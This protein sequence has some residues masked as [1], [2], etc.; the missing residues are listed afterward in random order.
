MRLTILFAFAT[1]APAQV[2]F[3]RIVRADAEPQNWLTYSGNYYGHRFSPLKQIHTGNVASLRT[4]WVYQFEN[5]R[6]QV[7]P[8][9]VNG[10][11]YITAPNMAAALDAKTGRALWTWRRPIPPELQTIGFGRVNRGAAILDGNLYVGTLDNYL[12]A[13]DIHSGAVRWE[14]KTADHRLGYCLT[15]A[16]LAVKDKIII[17]TAG[18]EAGIRGYIAAY[19]AK[20]GKEAWRLH[21]VPAAGE[22]GV[23]TWGG[24]SWKYG[25]AATWVTGSYDPDLNLIY[26]GTG[27]PGPDW[28]GDVR[29]GD[30]LYSCSLLAIDA[31]TGKRRWHF[32]FTPHDTH[33]WDATQTPVLVELPIRGQNRKV[34]A[35]ANRNGFYYILDRQTG[36]FLSGRPYAK[37]TWAKGLDDKGRPIVIPG[38]EPSEAGTLVWPSLQGSTNW[39]A[40]SYSP[41]TKLYYVSVREM[42]AYYY[43]G[44]AEYRP[45]TFYAGGGERSLKSEAWGAVRALEAD[46][47]RLKWEFKLAS[48]PWAGVMAT[49]GGLVFGG[50]DEGNFYALDAANGKPLWDFQAGGGI[51]CNPVSF[52][53]EGKQYVAITADRV[54]FVFGL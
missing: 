3:P 1:L 34:I 6:T 46:S 25:A 41:L 42:G 20:T 21:T 38:T 48:P 47:G 52:A 44:E 8:I 43:K 54:L 29:P 16:P 26:W 7:S 50:S 45:L 18:G 17:G 19:D 40:P 27:N 13:L 36:E 9:V 35:T 12:V 53:I 11:M 23:E 32:Q 22:P 14:T 30:N 51:F 37:Q 4:K 28:N 15:V 2:P 49:A 5:P 10:V 24:E 31:D 33:D 39:F